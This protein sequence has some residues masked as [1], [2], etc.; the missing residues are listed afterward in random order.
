MMKNVKFHQ[1]ARPLATAVLILVTV[2]ASACGVRATVEPGPTPLPPTATAEPPTQVPGTLE[3]PD[4]SEPTAP[5]ST[6][7]QA[8]SD[9]ALL[10]YVRDLTAIQP[11]SGWRSPGT[12]GER[13]ALDYVDGV[14]DSFANLKAMGLTIEW[15]EF[16]IPVATEIWETALDISVKGKTY[17]IPAD[18]L[19]GMVHDPELAQNFDTDGQ[20]GDAD[21]DPLAASGPVFVVDSREELIALGPEI[22]AIP[23]GAAPPAIPET[24]ELPE[25]LEEV[26]G[27]I[28]FI[29]YA[30]IDPFTVDE[31]DE[32]ES[33]FNACQTL[34]TN[35]AAGVVLVT[36]FSTEIGQSHG[37]LAQ[38]Y[39][40]FHFI[41]ERFSVPILLVRAEDLEEAGLD[42]WEDM[43]KVEEAKMSVDADVLVPARSANLAAF[44]PG[45]D[46]TKA[47]ILGAHIDSLDNPGALKN[48]SGAAILL[49]IGRIFDQANFR[50]G[51]TTW[52]VWFGSREPGFYGSY[53]FTATH[54]EL[55]DRT[56]AM[57]QLD[58]LTRPLDGLPAHI[59]L[60]SRSYLYFN[61][62]SLPLA[63]YLLK[64]ATRRDIKA[65][66]YD[67]QE[68]IADNAGFTGYNVPNVQMVYLDVEKAEAMAWNRDYAGSYY[69]PYDTVA[70]V[71]EQMVAFH[72]M[73]ELTLAAVLEL[74]ESPR[75][76]RSYILPGKKA[77]F[78]GSQTEDPHMTPAGFPYLGQAL[79]LKGFDVHLIPYGTPVRDEDLADAD[80]A[81][82]LPVVDYTFG[83]SSYDAGW[84]EEEIDVLARYAEQGGF[85]VL[86]NSAYRMI[87]ENTTQ[88]EN[89]DWPDVN[90]LAERFGVRYQGVVTAAASD[91]IDT[92]QH[93][94]MT[95][96]RYMELAVGNTVYFTMTLGTVL[97]RARGEPAVG[98]VHYERQGGEVLVLGDVGMLSSASYPANDDFWLSLADYV[99][100]RGEQ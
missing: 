85:L 65:G 50:P 37:A 86:T 55:M 82:A 72:Q 47:L 100:H 83:E 74:G 92:E 9:Q 14:L 91:E 46:D 94:I 56:L 3:V 27:K 64:V 41:E 8:I 25:A 31:A 95:G 12:Q 62:T 53:Q 61:E 88:E 32:M 71:E 34:V 11:Y 40:P 99:R 19:L 97:A 18:G 79:A 35:G 13:E 60:R 67:A 4:T 48:A 89:E 90:A 93:P 70:L 28:V 63:D 42:N 22:P 57:I 58:S 15:E 49:E 5:P 17:R 7:I 81:I 76:L 77:V 30:F 24:P 96:Q 26:K 10:G 84:S 69:S 29:D 45:R 87:H 16:N 54:Q 33:I 1:R 43:Q 52:L 38:S 44:I 78:V 80:L 23:D 2:L 51:V 73:A 66:T 68:A 59:E 6:L 20:W 21:R 36:H 39:S 98:L 75:E